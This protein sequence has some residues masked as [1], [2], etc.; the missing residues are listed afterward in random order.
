[1]FRNIQ[2]YEGVF[3][4]E[5]GWR[6]AA[7][8]ERNEIAGNESELRNDERTFHTDWLSEYAGRR[9][10]YSGIVTR[11]AQNATL[12]IGANVPMHH[13]REGGDGEYRH[14]HQQP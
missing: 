13:G 8:T 4:S 9:A 12:L 11:V 14:H 3:E 2:L 7:G 5:G 10:V 1:M 6:S